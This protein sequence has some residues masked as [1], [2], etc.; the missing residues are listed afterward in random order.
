MAPQIARDDRLPITSRQRLVL[1]IAAGVGALVMLVIMFFGLIEIGWAGLCG[2]KTCAR[3]WH[4][5]LLEGALVLPPIAALLFAYRCSFTRTGIVGRLLM[6]QALAFSA[7][8]I[9]WF[10]SAGTL[11]YTEDLA[12][13]R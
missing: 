12:L 6:A 3:G 11:I 5:N 13:L 1:I 8:V 4:V 9:V 10:A 2:G 7:A